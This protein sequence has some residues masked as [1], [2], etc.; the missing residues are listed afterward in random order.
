MFI[1]KMKLD[2]KETGEEKLNLS[3]LFYK[4][5]QKFSGVLFFLSL[6]DMLPNDT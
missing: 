6:L 3:C 5:D 4:K 2:M 1:T